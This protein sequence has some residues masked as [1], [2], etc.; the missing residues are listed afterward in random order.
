MQQHADVADTH[1]R[2]QAC[3]KTTRESQFDLQIRRV[4]RKPPHCHLHDP[5]LFLMIAVQAV[6]QKQPPCR[7]QTQQ[8]SQ[9]H[10]NIVKR[11]LL[12]CAV[13]PVMQR[14]CCC[15]PAITAC[16]C[17]RQMPMRQSVSAFVS[18]SVTTQLKARQSHP[19][20]LILKAQSLQ[21]GTRQQRERCCTAAAAWLSP[22]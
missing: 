17:S 22:A 9:N 3:Q 12:C 14:S 10:G 20:C 7:C 6:I 19:R 1:N 4:C 11:H 18:G 16:C 8:G 13:L 21:S 2:G 5:I 15:G